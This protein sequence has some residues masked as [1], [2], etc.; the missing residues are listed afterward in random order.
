MYM[1]S[2]S[3]VKTT[4]PAA[5]VYELDTDCFVSSLWLNCLGGNLPSV[6]HLT[7]VDGMNPTLL[8]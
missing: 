1:I 8:I 7:S 4:F 6:V 3:G 2:S 5:D